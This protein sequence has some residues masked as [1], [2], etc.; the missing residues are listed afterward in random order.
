MFQCNM[1]KIGIQGSH[2]EGH[3]FQKV[4]FKSGIIPDHVTNME[5]YYFKRNTQKVQVDIR[6]I[7]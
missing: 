4:R 2:H 6:T 7:G 1:D 3:G 5:K